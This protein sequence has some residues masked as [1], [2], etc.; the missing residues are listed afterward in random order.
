MDIKEQIE[1]MVEK[2]KTDK[3][4]QKLFTTDLI[5][6]VEKVLGVDLPNDLIE[7]I[8]DAVK[9]KIKIDDIGDALGALKKLF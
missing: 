2:V 6:G 8:I 1:K 7:K 4:I 9:A 5:K 3:E